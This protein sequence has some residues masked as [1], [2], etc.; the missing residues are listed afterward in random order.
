LVIGL[1]LGLVL[2]A[3]APAFAL[4]V[5][6]YPTKTSGA[7]PGSVALGPDGNLWFTEGAVNMIGKMTQAGVADDFAL[8]TGYS[9]PNAIIAGPDGNMWF[10]DYDTGAG[11]GAIGWFNPSTPTSITEITDPAMYLPGDM[12][13]GPDGNIWFLDSDAVGKMLTAS[14]H[15]VTEYPFPSSLS[16]SGPREITVG[17]D[18]RFWF[19]GYTG[20]VVR[21]DPK[22]LKFKKYAVD[23]EEP[24]TTRVF[25][26]TAGPDGNMWF[27][28]FVNTSEGS[29]GNVTKLDTDMNYVAG[30]GSSSSHPGALSVG[31]GGNVWVDD[32][33]ANDILQLDN[34]LNAL[35][36]SA[37]PTSGPE[38]SDLSP[39]GDGNLWFTESSPSQ[40]GQ[41]R[42]PHL[43]IL[44]V[45]YI[46]NFF[47]KKVAPLKSLGETVTW[48][49]MN[50]GTHGVA[51]STGM[52]LFGFGSPTGGPSPVAIGQSFSFSFDWAGTYQY[53]DPFHTS[54]KAKVKVPTSVQPL[55]GAPG[56]QVDWASADAPAGF[57]FD[58][59]VK[60]PGSTSFSDWRAGITDLSGAFTPSDPLWAGPGQYSFRAR[61]RNLSSGDASGYSAGKSISLS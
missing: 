61:L 46:P 53:N 5:H 19:V 32:S 48:V 26:I 23:P 1:S 49:M 57:A 24:T 51:D 59:Q 47:V 28:W 13:V 2:F 37:I 10:S 27:T 52:H 42:L 8:P 40:L 20:L 54:S 7:E 45:Y 56:A 25:D 9:E 60:V 38:V 36:T 15:T 50:P 43:S 4:V 18:Q 34:S 11:V 33:A 3:V 58:V 39:G 29:S 17:P 16:I 44:N 22:T 30:I 55:V 35:T 6:E 12:T 21:F 14:P 41:V 31:P